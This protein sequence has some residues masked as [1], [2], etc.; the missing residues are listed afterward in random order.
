[1]DL[2]LQKEFDFIREQ[3]AA[4]QK[5]LVEIKKREIANAIEGLG[6]NWRSFEPDTK[7]AQIEFLVKVSDKVKTW[8]NIPLSMKES[9]QKVINNLI[10]HILNGPKEE[11]GT[12]ESN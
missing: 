9:F 10:Q 2:T 3:I 11:N 5:E 1:M 8:I 7:G 12:G 4:I 6:D